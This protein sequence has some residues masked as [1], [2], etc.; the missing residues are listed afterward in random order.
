MRRGVLI[1]EVEEVGVDGR[2]GGGE[3]VL[4]GEVEGEGG[5]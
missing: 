2:S 1:R 3:G 5:C 4:M